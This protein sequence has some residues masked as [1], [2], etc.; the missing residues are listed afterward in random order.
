[1]YLHEVDNT[2]GSVFSNRQR[3]GKRSVTWIT[4]SITQ[5]QTNYLGSAH[6]FQIL[7][8]DATSESSGTGEHVI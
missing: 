1:M 4:V 6:I 7:R 8:L 5:I 2:Y 3:G